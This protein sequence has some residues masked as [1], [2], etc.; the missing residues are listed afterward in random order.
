MKI[1]R[2]RRH[3]AAARVGG[4]ASGLSGSQTSVIQ[5][6][7]QSYNRMS[8]AYLNNASSRPLPFS[9][10]SS[11]NVRRQSISY[12]VSLPSS[13]PAERRQNL[14]SERL[15]SSHDTFLSYLGSFIGRLHLQ[16]QSSSDLLATIRQSV[17][18][19][20]ELL[21]VTEVIC[22]HDSQSFEYLEPAKEAMKDRINQ[23]VAS[24]RDIITSSSVDGEDVVMPHHNG[25][26]LMAATGCVK[27]AGECVAK[28][29]F[30][31]QRIGDFEFEFE[32]KGLGIDLESIGVQLALR[33]K[34]NPCQRQRKECF[35]PP[36]SVIRPS[37]PPLIIPVCEKPLPEVPLDSPPS[38]VN[39]AR[40]SPG[41][42]HPVAADETVSVRRQIP[43]DHR[44]DQ[45]CHHYLG[46]A[47]SCPAMITVPQKTRPR[48]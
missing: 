20:Q 34:L 47:H 41:T 33:R 22:G 14:I 2:P 21:T 16:S 15:N 17:T 26:L 19:G 13:I 8:S 25:P 30:V 40:L 24:A 9:R 43:N 3:P 11:I 38:E 35:K 10:P 27:A 1:L 44:V 48:T 32:S 6:N 5:T 39:V 31:I 45:C 29:K 23:L 7:K 37:L 36:E 42:P 4:S 46:I 18:A 12:R 28:T